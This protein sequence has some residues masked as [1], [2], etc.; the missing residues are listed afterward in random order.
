MGPV[1]LSDEKLDALQWVALDYYLHE[2]NHHNGLVGDKTQANSL[3]SIAAV[4]MALATAPV[5]ERGILP[6]DFMAKRVLT[7]LRFFWNSPQGPEP[8]STGY[9]GFYYQFLDMET[10]KHVWN[11][12]LSTIDSAFLVAGMLTVATY[13]DH[14]TEDEHSLRTLAD[15]LFR[16]ADWQWAQNGGAT[17]THGWKPESGFLPCRWEG[18]DE[19]LLL[20]VLGLGS[21]TFV[22]S[23]RELRRLVFHLPMERDL[24]LR[25]F[26]LRAALYPSTVAHVDRLPRHPGRLFPRPGPG[27]LREQPAGDLC[28]AAIRHSQPP[29]VRGLQRPL[30]GDHGERRPRLD[31]ALGQGHRATVL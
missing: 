19:A 12:E 11:C 24:W 10:G 13:F 23:P 16:R 29:R 31:G 18:Y 30:L 20:Y 2:V 17:V 22:L 3:A 25:V 21:P 28:A 4:G 14:D 15:A 8:D 6:R 1:T 27:L 26:V 9:R 5:V 7:K